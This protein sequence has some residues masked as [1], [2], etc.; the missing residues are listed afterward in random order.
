MYSYLHP[1]FRKA[2]FSY[3]CFKNSQTK[4]GANNT[5]DL[6]ADTG[7]HADGRTDRE[8]QKDEIPT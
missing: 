7:L 4:F 2:R 8:T 6:L 1:D 5:I 3:K